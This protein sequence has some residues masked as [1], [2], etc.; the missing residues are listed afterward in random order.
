MT[1]SRLVL[2]ASLAVALGS[3]ASFLK[4]QS[5]NETLL[6]GPVC[7][8]PN[9]REARTHWRE[10]CDASAELAGYDEGILRGTTANDN[11]G[12]CKNADIDPPD[13]RPYV[14]VAIDHT[15]Q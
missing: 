10:E 15:T 3:S 11:F 5:P 9:N 6:F 13:N 12:A 1:V 8:E 4:A 14:C 7:F 2:A